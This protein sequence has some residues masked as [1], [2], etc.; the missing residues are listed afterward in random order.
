[1]SPQHVQSG[2][3]QISVRKKQPNHS[4][5]LNDKR[6]TPLQEKTFSADLLKFLELEY[7]EYYRVHKIYIKI[8][9]NV[10]ATKLQQWKF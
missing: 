4:A 2:L 5:D 7:F 8:P 3:L 10:N 1:M 6:E 9:Q